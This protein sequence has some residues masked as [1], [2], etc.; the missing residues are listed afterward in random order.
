MAICQREIKHKVINY[1]CRIKTFSQ[2]FFFYYYDIV[3]EFVLL[4]LMLGGSGVDLLLPFWLDA[5]ELSYV[6]FMAGVSGF[7]KQ[8]NIFSRSFKF[9]YKL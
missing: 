4:S 1:C 9:S 7:I 2:R 3:Q 6:H 8:Q 5:S